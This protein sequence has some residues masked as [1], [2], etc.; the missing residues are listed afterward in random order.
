LALN[1][2]FTVVEVSA[3]I[4]NRLDHLITEI[5]KSPDSLSDTDPVSHH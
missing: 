2:E 5:L 1:D 4:I 3:Y